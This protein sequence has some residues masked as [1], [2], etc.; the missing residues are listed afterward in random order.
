MSS[1]LFLGWSGITWQFPHLLEK[2]DRIPV[3]NPAYE[4][5][6]KDSTIPYDE[7]SESQ[8]DR[9]CPICQIQ[10]GQPAENA[11]TKIVEAPQ[12]LQCGHLFGRLCLMAWFSTAKT[13]P[14]CRTEIAVP[15]RQTLE[16]V[17]YTKCF[18]HYRHWL[19]WL[20]QRHGIHRGAAIDKEF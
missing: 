6:I 13:C 8:H 14:M 5:F 20:I 2:L 3:S 18:S 10:Y 15:S 7:L 12:R 1:W 19:I 4:R 17:H 16:G 9:I 11:P